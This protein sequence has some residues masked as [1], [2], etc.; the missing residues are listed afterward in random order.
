[1]FQSLLA[2]T[3]QILTSANRVHLPSLSRYGKVIRDEARN[4]ELKITDAGNITFGAEGSKHD[5][6][7]MALTYILWYGER[8]RGVDRPRVRWI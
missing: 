7:I 3:L 2:S 8:R 1:M 6:L 5:D 4:F